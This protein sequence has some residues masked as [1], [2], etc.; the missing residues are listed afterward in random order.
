MMVM[1]SSQGFCVPAIVLGVLDVLLFLFLNTLE[2][3]CFYP[4]FTDERTG[5]EKL[6][7]SPTSLS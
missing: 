4:C 2:G 6:N 5:P 1:V 7:D 3:R